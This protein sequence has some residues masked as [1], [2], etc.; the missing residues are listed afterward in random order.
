MKRPYVLGET[1]GRFT[2]N[3]LAFESKRLGVFEGRL[4][5]LFL[6]RNE[7]KKKGNSS[8][9]ISCLSFCR[10]SGIRTHDPLLPKQVR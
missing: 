3:A 8:Y 2:L 10:G 7:Y 1:Q 6:R 9:W 5:G 4:K